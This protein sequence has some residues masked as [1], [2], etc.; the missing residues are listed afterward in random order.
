MKKISM[1]GKKEKDPSLMSTCA[2]G[3]FLINS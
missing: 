3:N 1:K 2:L